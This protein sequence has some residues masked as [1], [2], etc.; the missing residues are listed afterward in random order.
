MGTRALIL[1]EGEKWI[2]THR[3]GGPGDMGRTLCMIK[4]KSKVEQ[5]K[6]LHKKHQIDYDFEKNKLV[7]GE[8]EPEFKEGI[9]NDYCD[10]VW[11]MKKEG[12]YYQEWGGLSSGYKG[13][14]DEENFNWEKYH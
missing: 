11:N 14:Q 12:I 2:Y 4:N 3:D 6:T 13:K 1:R 9:H 5:W 10:Y 7:F 8:V